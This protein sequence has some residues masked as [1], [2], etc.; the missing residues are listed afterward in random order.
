MVSQVLS[1]TFPGF[2]KVPRKIKS[3][4]WMT[5]L[6]ILLKA[7]TV[8]IF[9]TIELLVVITIKH[10]VFEQKRPCYYFDLL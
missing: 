10:R 4:L 5:I 8:H 2:C 6:W 1:K 9:T 7:Q 3:Y